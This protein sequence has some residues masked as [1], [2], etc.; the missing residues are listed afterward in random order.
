MSILK[1]ILETYPDLKLIKLDELDNAIIGI[2]LNNEKLVYSESLVLK[3]LQENNP[4]WTEE[5]CN[6]WYNYNILGVLA[7]ESMPI[8]I[9]LWN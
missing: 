2:D 1:D 3:C 9:Q 5:D 6:E 8:I 4:E 7:N